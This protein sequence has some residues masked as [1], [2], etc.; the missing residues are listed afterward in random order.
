MRDYLSIYL[1]GRPIRV[2]GEDAFLTVTDFVRRRQRL[3]GTKVVCAEGDCGSCAALIGRVSPDGKHLQYASVTA[4]IVGMFQLDACHIVTIEG[5][6]DG[7]ELNPVQQSM[8]SCHGAQCG[9]CTPGFV[10]SLYDLMQDGRP[11]DSESVRRGLTGNL[12][13]CTGYDSII[14]AALQT[15]RQKLKSIEQLY[16]PEP[17]LAALSAAAGEEVAIDAGAR[18]FYKPTTV[19]QA[20]DFRAGNPAC[21]IVSGATDVGVQRNKG[22]RKITVAMSMSG[23]G[24][25]RR[26][27]NDGDTLCVGAGASLTELQKAAQ[28]HLPELAA[29]LEWFGSPMIRNAG[30][31]A[32]NLVNASPI[33]DTLPALF[34][35]D[36][37]VELAGAQGRRWVNINQFYAGYRKTVLGAGE[38]V[39]SVRIPLPAKDQ[40][41]KLYKVSKRKDLDISGFGAAFWMRPL[42]RTIGDIRIAYGGVAPTVI[43]LPR[44]EEL[45]R[46]SV[47]SL[48]LFE[49]A[50]LVAREE[51][52]PI[53][54][55]RGSADYRRVLAGNI[56]TKF[57]HDLGEIGPMD[58]EGPVPAPPTARRPVLAQP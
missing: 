12:C 11:I 3:T 2:A 35:L 50:G 49:R 13:R 51:V 52:A 45:L 14:R 10:V 56:L 40:V 7:R 58:G 23:V 55:V 26:I 19:Q 47:M 33:G 16:P 22:T 9:F 38:I 54:D 18:R 20:V 41:Y 25:L 6:R 42:G 1:N 8:V 4:C 15:D 17:I 24:E 32:G 29:F 48:E 28:S 43:R 30:T 31:L 53:S 5:L 46:G 39:A 34:V 37:Q 36:A 21:A 57:W 44:T 27:C